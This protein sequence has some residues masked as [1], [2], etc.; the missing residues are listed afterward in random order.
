DDLGRFF[1]NH[2]LRV[3]EFM[4]VF[5]T[6]RQHYQNLHQLSR[7]ERLDDGQ[8]SFASTLREHKISAAEYARIRE[9]LAGAPTF[10]E[11]GIFSSMWSEHCSYKSS[12]VHL[13]KLPTTGENVV[14]GPGE[15]AGVVRIAGDL[16]VA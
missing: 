14:V 9:L 7:A 8:S 15:N 13:K 16:C 11:L 12:R 3:F 6:I 4:S 2:A 5:D 1:K 10:T